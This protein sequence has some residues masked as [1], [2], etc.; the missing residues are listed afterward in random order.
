MALRESAARI[1]EA[2][3]LWVAQLDRGLSQSEQTALDA[4]IASDAR[5]LGALARAQ[6]LWVETDRAQIY[7]SA[8]V[9][10]EQDVTPRRRGPLLR[11][12]AVAASIALVG[13]LGIYFWRGYQSTHLSTGVGEIRRLPLADG[14]SV[15]LN[16]RSKINVDYSTK[17]RIVH[18][19]HGEALFSVAA[20][21]HRPFVV[22]AGMVRVRAVGTEFVVR[23]KGDFDAEVTVT[24]GVVDV[25]RVQAAPEPAL[26]LAAGLRTVATPS[27]VQKPEALDASEIARAVAWQDGIIDLAGRTLAEAAAE[28][29]RYNNS[30]VVIS[31]PDLAARAVVGRFHTSDPQGFATAAAAMLDA[32]VRR[33]EDRILIERRSA[34]H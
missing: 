32:Q 30:E 14:S 10:A 34:K 18:L 8:K 27:A 2:A 9:D 12:M 6:A 26:R 1:E 16:T 24:R 23:R 20:D 22:E 19:D 11:W 28:F 3:A 33:E 31:D 25:W 29:N 13:I 21:V 7:Q 5:H 15:T 17:A 4:W